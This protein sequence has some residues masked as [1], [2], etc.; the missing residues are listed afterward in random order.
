MF[1]NDSAEKRVA[2]FEDTMELCRENSRLSNAI[3]HTISNTQFYP[4][5]LMQNCWRYTKKEV[6]VF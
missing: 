5:Q 1:H 4:V 3:A 6:C 2:I